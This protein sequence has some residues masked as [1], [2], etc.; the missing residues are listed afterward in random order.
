[1]E[2]ELPDQVTICSFTCKFQST[3]AKRTS[4]LPF[5]RGGRR[6]ETKLNRHNSNGDAE[7]SENGER[8]IIKG[9]LRAECLFASRFVEPSRERESVVAHTIK[10]TASKCCRR[11]WRRRQ[12]RFIDVWAAQQFAFFRF[13]VGKVNVLRAPECPIQDTSPPFPTS[14]SSPASFSR[15]I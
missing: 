2:I 3:K 13:F 15:A 1:M 6:N 14:S 10:A 9:F 7:E 5:V 12:S 8:V 11:K 4:P